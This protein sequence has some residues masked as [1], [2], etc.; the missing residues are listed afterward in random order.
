MTGPARGTRSIPGPS[1]SD[2]SRPGNVAHVSSFFATVQ[3]LEEPA[4][5]RPREGGVGLGCFVCGQCWVCLGWEG[6]GGLAGR[7]EAGKLLLLTL[8]A[9]GGHVLDSL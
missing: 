2:G 6:G 8:H 9:L 4:E 5:A 1:F 3:M 7:R